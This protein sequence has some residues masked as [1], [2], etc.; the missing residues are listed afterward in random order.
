[1]GREE[2]ERKIKNWKIDVSIDDAVSYLC[3]HFKIKRGNELYVA[4]AD[5]KIELSQV[6]DILNH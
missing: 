4:I 3:K 1:M 2:L 5:Q 6:K